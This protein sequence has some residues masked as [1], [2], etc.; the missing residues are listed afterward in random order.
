MQRD[1]AAAVCCA[2]VRNIHCALRAEVGVE[3]I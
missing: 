1:R 3:R 2:Y